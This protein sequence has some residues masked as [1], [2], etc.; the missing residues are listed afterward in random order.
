VSDD[1]P[2]AMCQTMTV[3]RPGAS[4][5]RDGYGNKVPGPDQTHDITRCSIQPLLGVASVEQMTVD[6]DKVV[7]RWRFFAPPG[8][9]VAASDHVRCWAGDL[10]VDGDPVTWPDEDGQPHHVEG[11]LKKWSG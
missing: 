10:E 6:A 11:Y 5:G 8:A 2:D 9:D 3:V 4:T 1:L 7:T